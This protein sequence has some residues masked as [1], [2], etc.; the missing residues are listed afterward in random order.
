LAAVDGVG[1]RTLPVGV[2]IGF[3]LPGHEGG[4]IVLLRLVVEQ[5]MSFVEEL[6]RVALQLASFHATLKRV[7]RATR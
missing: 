2:E 4:E 3:L 1:S 7:V 6:A 5:Q